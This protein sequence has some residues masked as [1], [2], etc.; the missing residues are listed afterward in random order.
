MYE[1]EHVLSL[2]NELGEGPLW[3]V[4]EQ[5]IYWMDIPRNTLYKFTPE[6][7][8]FEETKL[9]K[10]PGCMAFRPDGKI[11]FATSDGFAIWDGSELKVLEENIAYKP[12]N[13]FN[14]GAVDRAGRFWA[15][16]ASDNFENH[17]Y[18]IDNDG[19]VTIM[20]KNVAISNGIGWSPDNKTM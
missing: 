5:A 4:R 9:P 2:N 18:R 17:L 12:A 15:G 16:T 10:T 11:V 1:V 13:R 3:N 20:E 7:N 8:Q 6:N 14:D 19:N